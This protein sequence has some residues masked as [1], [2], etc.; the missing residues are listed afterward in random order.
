MYESSPLSCKIRL[1]TP[2]PD[3]NASSEWQKLAAMPGV[4]H[5]T[6]IIRNFKPVGLRAIQYTGGRLSFLQ[7]VLDELDATEIDHSTL[8]S[9]QTRLPGQPHAIEYRDMVLEET[10]KVYLTYGR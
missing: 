7:T 1:V 5:N 8:T 4:F 9:H 3:D 6:D 10:T 2:H